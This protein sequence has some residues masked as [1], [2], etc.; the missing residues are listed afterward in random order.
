MISLAAGGSGGGGSKN[1][2]DNNDGK[3]NGNDQAPDVI[4]PSAHKSHDDLGLR[5]VEPPTRVFIHWKRSAT[6][7]WVRL[8]ILNELI[9]IH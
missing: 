1:D 5:P 9:R 8:L 2:D 6:A 4:S 3:N 7:T